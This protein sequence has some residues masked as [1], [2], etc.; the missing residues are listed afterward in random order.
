MSLQF[1]ALLKVCTEKIKNS[2]HN[3]LIIRISCYTPLF[4]EIAKGPR[5]SFQALQY[6]VSYSGGHDR[7]GMASFHDFFTPPPPPSKLMPPWGTSSPH[8]HTLKNEAPSD[9]NVKAPSRK[10]FLEKN[11]KKSESVINNC[12]SI[13]KQYWK[14]MTKAPQKRG[15]LLTWSIQKFVRKVKQF[16]RKYYITWLTWVT[17]YM[18]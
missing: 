12:I 11:Q 16:V 7:G 10:W 17:N 1:F 3:L 15:F 4:I 2:K 9:W 6:R 13:I 8:K 18:T 5:I 14:T